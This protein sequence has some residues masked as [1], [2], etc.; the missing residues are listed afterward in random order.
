MENIFT[1]EQMQA[2]V[3]IREKYR[4]ELGESFVQSGANGN[5]GEENE[6][7]NGDR[8]EEKE[9]EK[10][11]DGDKNGLEKVEGGEESGSS[12]PLMKH[13]GHRRAGADLFAAAE[14]RA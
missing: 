9:Q 13:S 14:I 4:Q 1:S 2:I 6:Q 8:K 5:E 10:E 7:T 12:E 11:E 3:A